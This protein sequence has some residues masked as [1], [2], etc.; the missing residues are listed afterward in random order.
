MQKEKYIHSEE[1]HNLKSPRVIVPELIRIFNPKSV[2]D[3][4]S[5]IG[6][7]LYCFKEAGVK[8]VLG[9]DG[10]WVNRELLAKYLEPQEFLEADLEKHILL[11]EKFDLAMSL[12]VAEH[13]SAASADAFVKTLTSASDIVVFSAAVV[14]QGG[15][16]HINEQW[17]SYWKEKFFLQQFQLHDIFKPL[18]WDNPDVHYWYKQNMVVFTRSNFD[19]S[20]FYKHEENSLQ[21]VIHPTLY[22]EKTSKLDQIVRGDQTLLYYLKLL[23]K[24]FLRRLKLR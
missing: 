2:L 1:L 22:L 20:R 6:T 4:G 10:K 13:V 18:L 8:K 12:E 5:G 11:P 7:F 9:I 3:V 17:L 21:N 14:R 15:Q 24:F 23:T 19:V 16:N